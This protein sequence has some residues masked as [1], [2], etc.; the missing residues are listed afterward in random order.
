MFES[1]FGSLG[2]SKEQIEAEREAF[3]KSV[4]PFGSEQKDKI[5]ELLSHFY[6]KKNKKIDFML[7]FIQ[8]KQLYLKDRDLAPIRSMLKNMPVRFTDEQIRQIISLVILDS[9]VASLSE[10]PAAEQVK[11]YAEKL[12]I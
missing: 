3:E 4:F 2:K 12:E 5:E 9:D 7:A 8:G 11:A 1:L 6:E 10:Y